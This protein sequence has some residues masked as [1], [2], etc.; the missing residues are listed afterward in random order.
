MADIVVQITVTSKNSRRAGCGAAKADAEAA[1]TGIAAIFDKMGKNV[2]KHLSGL[3]SGLGASGGI[4]AAGSGLLAMAGPIGAAGL[5]LGAF[6]A[7]AIPILSKV[8]KAHQALTAAQLQ[9][10]K[11]TTAA[12]RATALKAEAAATAGLTSQ[13]K[14][15]MGQVAALGKQFSSLE[16]ILTPVVITVASMVA[17]LANALMPVLFTLATAG[18]K[19]LT[20]MLRPLLTL[21]SSPFFAQFTKQIAA[22]AVQLGTAP[23]AAAAELRK[24]LM[25][26]L[27]AV[28]PAA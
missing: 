23:G 11:A 9:Y 25:R 17:Q 3:G 10:N 26:L 24:R 27:I 14:G 13:Q 7:V 12:G 8:Q 2:N 18:A 4:L 20:G 28:R 5:A 19:L 6:G 15:L 16:A 21:I 1:A 22:M